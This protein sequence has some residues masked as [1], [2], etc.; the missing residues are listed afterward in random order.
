MSF[1][2]CKDTKKY[3]FTNSKCLLTGIFYSKLLEFCLRLARGGWH[4]APLVAHPCLPS[5][6]VRGWWL[7]VEFGGNGYLCT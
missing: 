1:S 5:A 6:G 7:L 3:W 2:N 4:G